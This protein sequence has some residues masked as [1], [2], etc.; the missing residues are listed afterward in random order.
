MSSGKPAEKGGEKW[1]GVEIFEVF[2]TDDITTFLTV[3][4]SMR[5]V[6]NSQVITSKT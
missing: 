2:V 1:V 4:Q 5:I 3:K 6:F